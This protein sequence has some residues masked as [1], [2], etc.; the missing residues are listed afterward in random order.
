MYVCLIGNDWGRASINITQVGNFTH[1][2][3]K[4]ELTPLRK[5]KRDVK[6]GAGIGKVRC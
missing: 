4:Y 6:A 2:P 5:V 3:Y 1:A